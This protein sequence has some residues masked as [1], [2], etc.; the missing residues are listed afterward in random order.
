M[1][2]MISGTKITGTYNKS[3]DIW[4]PISMKKYISSI[5]QISISH[6][7]PITVFIISRSLGPYTLDF[8]EVTEYTFITLRILTRTNAKGMRSK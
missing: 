8:K 1:N 6:V 5:R 7:V 3:T 4:T 2:P